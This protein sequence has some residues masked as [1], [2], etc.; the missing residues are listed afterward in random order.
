MFK[1]KK[2]PNPPAPRTMDEIQ[3]VYTEAL[4]K[5]AQAQYL[6][7]VH[8]LDLENTN[9]ELLAINHEAKARQD[10]DRASEKSTSEPNS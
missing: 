8:S 7:Y 6:V 10:L 3:K 9:K 2:I 4:S 5:A 1:K